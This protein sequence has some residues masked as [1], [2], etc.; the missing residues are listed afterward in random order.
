MFCWSSL[1]LNLILFDCARLFLASQDLTGG[2]FEANLSSLN[3]TEG[4]DYVH[5]N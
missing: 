4:V 3:L 2:Q 5:F 1:K